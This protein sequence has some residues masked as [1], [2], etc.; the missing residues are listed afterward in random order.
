MIYLKDNT[1]WCLDARN[2]ESWKLDMTSDEYGVYEFVL[3]GTTIYSC[4]PWSE[5]QNCW[6]L[7]TDENG[8]PVST[9]L[10]DDNIMD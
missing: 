10:T 9:T 4:A 6:E 7:N 1:F 5:K 8:K 3:D 2:N